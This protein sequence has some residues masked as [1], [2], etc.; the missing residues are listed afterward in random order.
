[1]NSLELDD[2]AFYICTEMS[3]RCFVVQKAIQIDRSQIER[4]VGDLEKAPPPPVDAPPAPQ[5][6]YWFT[7]ECRN[8]LVNCDVPAMSVPSAP[9]PIPPPLPMPDLKQQLKAQLEYYFSRENL[10]TDR[11]LRCQMDA[12]QFVPISIIAG[13]RKIVQLTSD[14][15][16][17]LQVLRE[18]NQV[19]VDERGEKV[20]S[21]CR[22]CTIILREISEE[23]REEVE[24]MLSGGPP[25]VDLKYGLNNSWYVTFDNE[26]TT[27]QAYLHLQNMNITF[28]NKP[29]CA[30]I[31]AGGPPSDLP[32]I[33]R[34]PTQMPEPIAAEPQLY[35]PLYELGQLLAS[36]GYVPRA[37]FRPGATVVHVQDEARQRINR[38]G[39]ASHQRNQHTR[40]A[41]TYASGANGYA[42]HSNGAIPSHSTAV[43]NGTIPS[44]SH[45]GG[46]ERR[47]FREQTSQ[48]GGRGS[49]GGG[50]P[51]RGTGER[52]YHQGGRRNGGANGSHQETR[53]RSD[54]C[55]GGGGGGG[56]GNTNNGPPL[57]VSTGNIAAAAAGTSNTLQIERPRYNSFRRERNADSDHFS[58]NDT[59]NTSSGKGRRWEMD[60]ENGSDGHADRKA[61][62]QSGCSAYSFEERAFPSLSEPKPEPE[63]PVEKPSFSC[64][65]AGK[66]YAK[67]EPRKSYAEKLKEKTAKA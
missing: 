46:M 18:S 1:M 54:Y 12:D 3:P 56:G 55:N 26:E 29:I 36:Y 24:K 44:T 39:Q 15:N 50:G 37:T 41:R 32:P 42:M 27:Q 14:Y 7:T 10:I 23:H 4:M 52:T 57:S 65:A 9:S 21:V 63:K 31:K 61:S 33:D 51:R 60:S 47:H 66:R 43:I 8:N 64:V 45:Y 58:T 48:R 38:H 22:R 20:R 40:S 2:D 16:L 34:M 13:F 28:N 30:R 49:A 6:P 17:I 5:L 35:T 19:E 62:S 53:R 25:Y 59:S 11:Y 67:P